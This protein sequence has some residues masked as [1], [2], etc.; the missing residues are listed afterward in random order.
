MNFGIKSAYHTW[1]SAMICT[2]TKLTLSPF[3][4]DLFA[5]AV[6]GLYSGFTLKAV[7]SLKQVVHALCGTLGAP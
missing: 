3:P 7:Q 5:V 2:H 1:T 6:L 4:P